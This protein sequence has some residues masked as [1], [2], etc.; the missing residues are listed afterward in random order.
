MNTLVPIPPRP[1]LPPASRR[2]ARWSAPVILTVVAGMVFA[3][4]TATLGR[5]AADDPSPPAD[6]AYDFLFVRVNGDPIRWNPCAPIAYEVNLEDAPEDALEIVEEAFRRTTE[7]SG[8]PFR[9]VGTTDRTLEDQRASFLDTLSETW[10]PVLVVWLPRGEFRSLFG[11]PN[12]E[13]HALAVASTNRGRTSATNDQYASGFIA[14]DADAPMDAD[15]SGRYSLGLVLMH[16]AAH[17]MGLGHVKAPGEVMFA[18]RDTFPLPLDDWG[19]GDREGL[20]TLGAGACED[21]V[22]VAR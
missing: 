5:D 17:V 14:V 20:E 16:E 11:G 21:P 12:Q 15:F 22:P 4:V 2:R 18:D 8:V 13:R 6:P 3:F 10:E 9:F 19:P 7:V 1:D